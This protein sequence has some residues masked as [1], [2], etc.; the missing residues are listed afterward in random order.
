[1]CAGTDHLCPCG[2]RV[3]AG[4]GDSLHR[5]RHCGR[6]FGEYD[7]TAL[8]NIYELPEIDRHGVTKD[9]RQAMGFP[10]SG[11]QNA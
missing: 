3:N 10:D 2:Y 8:P 5:C 11:G 9:G 7:S 4:C 6:Q 1:M